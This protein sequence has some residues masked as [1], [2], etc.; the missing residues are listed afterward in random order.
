MQM[1]PEEA[2]ADENDN[3]ICQIEHAKQLNTPTTV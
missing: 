3:D 2:L 1:T